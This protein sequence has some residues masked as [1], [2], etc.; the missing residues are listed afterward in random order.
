MSNSHR[1]IP[2]QPEELGFGGVGFVPYFSSRTR[3]LSM[4][5]VARAGQKIW[6]ASLPNSQLFR[7]FGYKNAYLFEEWTRC[8]ATRS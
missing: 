4:N 6:D 5:N 8:Q 2:K 3:A 7:L 1:H